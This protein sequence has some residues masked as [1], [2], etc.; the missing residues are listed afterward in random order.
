MNE[1]KLGQAWVTANTSDDLPDISC[2]GASPPRMPTDD[3]MRLAVEAYRTR[4]IARFVELGV[5]EHA[6]QYEW[7]ALDLS[8]VDMSPEELADECMSYWDAD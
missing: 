4:F 6:A 8:E 2:V 3:E 5:P 7:D 1:F